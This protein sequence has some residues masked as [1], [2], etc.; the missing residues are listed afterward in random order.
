MAR[1]PNVLIG[2]VG[3][4]SDKLE[5]A[6]HPHRRYN[7][8]TRRWLLCSPHRAKRPWL[9]SEVGSSSLSKTL[10]LAAWLHGELLA[11]IGS[12]GAV[13]TIPAASTE[14]PQSPHHCTYAYF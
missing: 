4:M 12:F 13:A 14:C 9:G 2:L 11:R 7:P 3:I 10:M 8:L 6:D 1:N 5:Y